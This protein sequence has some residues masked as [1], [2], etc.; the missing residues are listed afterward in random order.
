MSKDEALRLAL[1]AL[2][3]A[4]DKPMWNRVQMESAITA[5]KSAL[6]AKDEPFCWYDME[7]GEIQ[8]VE[9]NRKKPTYEGNWKPLY[10]TPPQRTWIGLTKEESHYKGS[11]N[12]EGVDFW[13]SA[14]LKEGKDGTKFMS[15]SVKA[16][17][18]KEA[19]AP[20]KRSPRQDFD[21]DAPF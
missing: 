16:K 18:Q 13:I 4:L 6:E 9:W 3:D 8:D 17:D 5:I 15:L 21:E 12:V 1:E 2:T 14:W 7:H 10:K 20:T 11:L 19:K